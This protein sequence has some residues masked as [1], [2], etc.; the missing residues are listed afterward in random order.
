MLRDRKLTPATENFLYSLAS[1]EG[2]A[3]LWRLQLT[4]LFVCLLL[5]TTLCL[6]FV[7]AHHFVFSVCCCC[8]LTTLCVHVCVDLCTV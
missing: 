3:Q 8:V 2:L 5:L 1:V 6:V 7:V 4:T